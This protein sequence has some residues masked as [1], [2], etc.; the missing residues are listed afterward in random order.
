MPTPA[1]TYSLPRAAEYLGVSVRTLRRMIERG[2]V[3][4]YRPSRHMRF[5]QADLD[6]FLRSRTVG[7]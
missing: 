5:R 3:R 7:A 4:Y 6:E 2:V 1:T